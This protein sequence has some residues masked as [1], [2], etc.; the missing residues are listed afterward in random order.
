MVIDNVKNIKKINSNNGANNPFEGFNLIDLVP[1]SSGW[2]W[3]S[4]FYRKT[5]I[6]SY[7][8]KECEK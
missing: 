2:L 4:F 1:I 6:S 8:Q 7:H 5:Q 3:C